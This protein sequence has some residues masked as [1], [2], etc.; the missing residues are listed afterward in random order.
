MTVTYGELFAGYG[1]MYLGLGSVFPGRLAWYSEF[2][3]APAKV[4]H[5]HHPESPNLGDVTTVDWSSVEPVNILTGGT[6]CQDLSSA[7]KRAG[8]REGTRSGLWASMVNAIDTLHPDLVVWENVRGATSA[9]ADSAVEFCQGCMGDRPEHTALRAL[10]RVLGDL[11]S[12]RYDA[13]WIGLPASDIGAAHR[14]FRLFVFAAP[15]DNHHPGWGKRSRAIP[16]GAQQHSLTRAGESPSTPDGLSLLPT[17]TTDDGG[18]VTRDSGTFQ[19]LT[20]TVYQAGQPLLP[21]PLSSDSSNLWHGDGGPSLA[22]VIQASGSL[23]LL[24]TP[25]V[26]DMGGN[27]TVEWWDAWTDE[28][29]ARLGNSNGHGKSLGIEARRIEGWEQ[30][31]PALERWAAVLG[32]SAPP[33]AIPDPRL[34]H[35][36]SPR[37]AEWMMGLP[38][39]WVSAVPGLSASHQLTMLGNGVVPQQVA[40]AA[41]LWLG[42]TA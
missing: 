17:L 4:M 19:S 40:A 28:L 16:I 39:G 31:Q 10:G 37:F 3:K 14:R 2:A 20:R 13:W 27:K 5:H 30:Y 12:L 11:A 25:A 24:P 41:A 23:T 9:S 6:P 18:N 34:G 42:D 33:H 22:Q 38:D 29:D 26:N 36:L 32:R 7:G 15:A 35:R 8:M 1:G 21:T